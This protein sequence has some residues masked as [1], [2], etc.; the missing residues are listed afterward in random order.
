MR[1]G[2]LARAAGVGIDT[3]R[4]YERRG[5]LPVPGRSAAGYRIYTSDDLERVR[6]VRRAQGLGFTLAEAAGLLAL[7]ADDSARAGE[8][9]A[10]TRAKLAEQRARIADLERIEAALK[11][12]ADAC[13]V[14]APAGECP[15]LRHLAGQAPAVAAMK[16]EEP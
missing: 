8:V 1:I 7:R 16:G 3:V 9:L 11:Q 2:A 13:P 12:L 4:Y 5:L 15:I 10:A 14:E 6:F